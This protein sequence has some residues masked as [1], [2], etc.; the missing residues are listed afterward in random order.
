MVIVLDKKLL[1]IGAQKTLGLPTISYLDLR[2]KEFSSQNIYH[3]LKWDFG[4][5]NPF[6]ISFPSILLDQQPYERKAALTQIAREYVKS[7]V[8]RVKKEM[9]IIQINPIF[10]PASY[11][12]DP[13]LAFV[14][15]PF[16]DDLTKIYQTLIKPTIEE[17]DFGLVCRRADDIKSNRTIMQDIWKAICEA[18][19]ILADVTDLNP[20]VMYELGIAHT[21]GKETIIIYQKDEKIKFPFDLAHIRRIEYENSPVGGTTLMNDLKETIE[22]ILNPNSIIGD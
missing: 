1:H 8:Q 19:L 20:N 16:R 2:A 5:D 15:M 13:R 11:E 9:N 18:R 17:N 21:L 14:L 10:G 12:I 22:N 7:E 3:S 4:F 6:V